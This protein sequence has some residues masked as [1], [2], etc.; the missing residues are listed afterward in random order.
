MRHIEM[1]RFQE[2]ESEPQATFSL[3]LGMEEGWERDHTLSELL[4]TWGRRDK[5]AAREALRGSSL[6]DEKKKEFE[7]ALR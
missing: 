7:R 1:Q 5:D 4:R 2:G 3:F 6:S